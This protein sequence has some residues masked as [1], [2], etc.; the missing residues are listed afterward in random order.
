M[1]L[2]QKCPACGTFQK[3]ARKKC[4]CG[5]SLARGRKDNRV[6]IYTRL[7]GGKRKKLAMNLEDARVV[8]AHVTIAISEGLDPSDD[9]ATV[10]D[11]IAWYIGLATVRRLKTF[12]DTERS[13][14]VFAEHYGHRKVSAINRRQLIKKSDIKNYQLTRHKIDGLKP[15]SVDR[16]VGVI[17]TM[18]AT[19]DDD[20][21]INPACLRAFRKTK[22]LLIRGG[23]IRKTTIPLENFQKIY[24]ASDDMFQR[25]MTVALYTGMRAG[26]IRKL[27]PEQTELASR[28]DKDEGKIVVEGMM[29]LGPDMTK[30]PRD[31]DDP[32]LIPITPVVGDALTGMP[33]HIDLPNYFYSREGKALTDNGVVQRMKGG[34]RRAGIVYGR[35]APGGVTFHDIRR[36][37]KT[38]MDEFG[39]RKSIRDA[40]MGHR[41]DDMDRHYIHPPIDVIRA[42]MTDFEK[43]LK[44]RLTECTLCTQICTQEASTND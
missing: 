25:F 20:D 1:A 44:N 4:S 5:F 24:N 6:P 21:I 30:E 43:W 32:K 22:R 11:L 28:A 27:T 29:A 38:L 36:T 8:E 3:L 37:T 40:V 18:F 16:E 14:R 2:E 17:K 15:A 34:C 33:R 42:A 19:A 35:K 13:L 7:P 39:M 12:R 31:E 26:E 10:R 41:A 9:D 23:N